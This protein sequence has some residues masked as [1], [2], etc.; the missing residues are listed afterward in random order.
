MWLYWVF[1]WIRVGR[2]GDLTIAKAPLT[3]EIKAS[4][5][6]AGSDWG[7]GPYGDLPLGTGIQVPPGAHYGWVATTVQP[8]AETD[9]AIALAL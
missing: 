6:K 4:T 3:V 9:G 1:P 5:V 2:V 7:A 8:P